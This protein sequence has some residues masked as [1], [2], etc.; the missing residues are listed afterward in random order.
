MT[1]IDNKYVILQVQRR[2][3]FDVTVEKKLVKRNRR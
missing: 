1:R 2:T 3:V